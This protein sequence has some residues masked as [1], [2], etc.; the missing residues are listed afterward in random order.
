MTDLKPFPDCCG[1]W[2]WNFPDMQ[3]NQAEHD[4]VAAERAR[5][6]AAVEGLRRPNHER[7]TGSG[8]IHQA[9]RINALDAVL[10][11]LEE[12]P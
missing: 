1:A 11:L 9:G 3:A 8:E 5:I 2:R 6:R 7:L 4:A 10:A 12:T